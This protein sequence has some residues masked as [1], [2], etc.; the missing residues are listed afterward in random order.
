MKKILAQKKIIAVVGIIIIVGGSYYWYNSSK[1][2]DSAVQ[3]KTA[4]AEKGTLSV[5]V[6]GSGN[7]IVDDSANID[8]TITGTVANLSVAVGDEVKKGQFLFEIENEDLN[9]NVIKA[10]S[11]YLQSLSALETSKANKSEAKDN[12]EDADSDEKSIYKRK[13]EAAEISIKT[14]EENIKSTWESY[15]NSKSDYA[16][17]KV[18]ASIS[19]TVNAVN[20]KNGDD[21]SRLSGNSN[22]Q[23]PIVLGDLNT[24]K[25]QV[26]VSEVDIANVKISQNATLTFNAISD[27]ETSG[28]VEKIDSLG[29][30]TSGVVTY[31]VI[32]NFDSLD[33]K[34]KPGMSVSASI[35]T[36]VKQDTIIVP[37]SAVKLE[38]KNYY[39]EI[40]KNGIPNKKSVEI[41]LENTT[42]TEIVSGIS[43]GENVITQTIKAT[44]PTTAKTGTSTQRNSAVRI[45]GM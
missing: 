45:P 5:S 9:V 41:G 11:T 26:E 4:V 3:Y 21:L 30:S 35:I 34:I 13:L 17:R 44:S 1:K 39:V 16:K 15:Q 32:V 36:E 37:N 23:A 31:N 38:N 2:N 27:F 28:K 19:G 12:Y 10:Y 24:L 43:E 25:A 20:I 7:V 22:S 14:A 29:T 40:L 18:T 33:S 6:S 42:K 8:P